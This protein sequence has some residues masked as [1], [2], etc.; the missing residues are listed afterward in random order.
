MKQPDDSYLP[1]TMREQIKTI[2]KHHL[3]RLKLPMMSPKARSSLIS[4]LGKSP[5]FYTREL[6]LKSLRDSLEEFR[7]SKEYMHKYDRN[8]IPLVLAPSM[9]RKLLD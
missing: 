4:R 3:D 7:N 8:K 6:P 9:S 1:S 2:A 5:N